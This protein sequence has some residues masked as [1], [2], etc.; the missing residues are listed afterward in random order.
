MAGQ[1]KLKA[2]TELVDKLSNDLKKP[3]LGP[4]ERVQALDQLK[5]YGRDPNNADPIF[6][7][8]GII[9]L[10]QHA[11]E[12]DVETS[13]AALK[14]LAN[15]MLLQPQTRKTFI[16]QGGDSKACL[17]LKREGWDD[18]FLA[19]RVLFLSTYAGADLKELIEKNHLA[20]RIT[21]NLAR[22]VNAL[23]GTSKAKV[24]PMQ[25]MAIIESLKLLFN[26]TH[27]CESHVSEFTQAVP[28]LVTLFWEQEV[29]K[30]QPLDGCNGQIINALLNLDLKDE[31]SQ[32][33][34]F[35]ED[36]PTKTATK[37]IE[38]LD[39]AIRVYGENDL[40]AVVAPLINVLRKVHATAPQPVQILMRERI[41]PTDEDRKKVLGQ[42]ETLSAKLLKNSTHPTCQNLRD[43]ISQLLFDMSDR[44]AS[45]FVDNVGYGLA[46]GFLFQN[47]IPMPPSASESSNTRGTQQQVNPI[48]GQFVD[49]E[50][51]VDEPE[52][53]QE[54]REREAERLFVLFERLRATGVMD[55]VNPVEAAMRDG[56]YRELRDDEVEELDD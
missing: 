6:T 3:T 31:K 44:D 16:E 34:I 41:L 22:H 46:S 47:N 51:P 13:R 2:V 29:S 32:A 27:F 18:E 4:L 56:T 28:P 26:V 19:S 9:M 33:A 21:E 11:F 43:S 1:L 52:M 17:I 40:D 30:S 25:G 35:P 48:T 38:L 39:P 55:V 54:E 5:L 24:D 42:G 36:D 15:S 12:S 20:D 7:K 10:M 49:A 45:K 53:T 8:N 50:T 14:V 23:S 37:L